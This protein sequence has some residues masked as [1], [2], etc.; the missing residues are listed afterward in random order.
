MSTLILPCAGKST[1]FPNMKPKWMLTHPDG[2]LMVDKSMDGLPLDKFDKII[3][4]IVKDHSEKYEAKIIL[5]QVF[6]LQN[7]KKIEILELDDF[8]SCQAETV[9]QTIIKK[10]IKDDFVVK[11]SDNMVRIENFDKKDF[12]AGL[13]INKFDK[14]IYRLKSKSFL[15]INDQNIIVDIVEKQIRSENICLGVYGFGEPEKFKEAYEFLSEHGN[16]G[17]IYLSHVISYLIGTKKSIYSYIE[18]VDFEDWGTLQDWRITQNRHSTYF[19][20]IDGIVLT[21][22]GKY[23]KENWSNCLPVIDENL[24]ILKNLYDE[25]AQI[26]FTTCRAEEDLIEFKKILEK[27]G[28]V[29]HSFV[30]KCNHSP[31]IMINDFAPTNPYP[32]C[33]AINVPRNGLITTYLEK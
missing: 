19:V 26:V 28:V 17:E 31:R 7:N 27:K 8:T 29:A 5:E 13:D 23:G 2:R 22:R 4:T 10:N 25:G 15:V 11:D 16:K 3:I 9:Y 1:R 14:E 32:S 21:N 24:N 20:D 12:I 18:T 30:T 33:K 6:G